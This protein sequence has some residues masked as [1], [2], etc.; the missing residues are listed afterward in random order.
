MKKF[1]KSFIYLL[2]SMLCLITVG[3]AKNTPT[4]SLSFDAQELSIPTDIALKTFVVNDGTF[5]IDL[6]ATW[7]QDMEN[8]DILVVDQ[9]A[10]HALTVMVERYPLEFVKEEMTGTDLAAFI[11]LYEKKGIPKLLEMATVSPLTEL[12]TPNVIEAR[13]YELTV[14]LE[15]KTNKAYFIYTQTPNAFYSI[16]INAE[17]D[18]YEKEVHALK[19]IPATLKEY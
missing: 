18:V 1:T 14:K 11:T 10:S 15:D 16:S 4:T 13:G 6:P 17:E 7:V 8:T 5:S 2:F 3:C 19:Y 12:I 9:D